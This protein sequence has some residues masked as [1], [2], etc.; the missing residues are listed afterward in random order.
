MIQLRQR[1]L[2]AGKAFAACR[3]K[4][5]VAE[6][7]DRDFSAKVT[8]FSKINDSHSAFTEQL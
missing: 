1:S 3:R 8:T 4:P 7:L 5:R 2:F 6:D